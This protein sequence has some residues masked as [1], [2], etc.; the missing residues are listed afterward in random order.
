MLKKKRLGVGFRKRNKKG[1]R[2]FKLGLGKKKLKKHIRFEREVKKVI[3][4]DATV[5]YIYAE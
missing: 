4:D 1:K 2:K 3:T 5:K